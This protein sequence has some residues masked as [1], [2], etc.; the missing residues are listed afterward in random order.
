MTEQERA[1]VVAILTG[2]MTVDE[3]PMRQRERLARKLTL[4]DINE[5]RD[6]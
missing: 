6:R 5:S 1:W 4:E 2:R 3:I